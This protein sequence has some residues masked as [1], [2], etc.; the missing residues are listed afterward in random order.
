MVNLLTLEWKK[1]KDNSVVKLFLLMFL[2]TLPVTIFMFDQF[3][4]APPPFPQTEDIFSFPGIWEYQFYVA[5]W[6]VFFFL[7]Y[8][9]IYMVTSEVDYK[10][11]RQNIIAGLTRKEFFLAKISSILFIATISTI[12]YILVCLAFGFFYNDP[13]SLEGAFDKNSLLFIAKYFLMNLAYMGFGLMLA[14]LIRKSGIAIFFYVS[15]II[16]I[17]PVIK[18]LS[19]SYLINE[20]SITRFVNFLPLNAIEDL[21]PLPFY[22]LG[23]NLP[24]FADGMEFL[25]SDTEAIVSSLIYTGIFYAVAYWIFMRRDL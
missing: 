13:V 15:Y 23:T 24:S 17:E 12:L 16:F 6:L 10:T 5:S 20:T 8:V 11:M 1:Y 21:G 3:K 14:M 9:V 2:I 25:L 18:V 19:A 4:K 22:K 7:G